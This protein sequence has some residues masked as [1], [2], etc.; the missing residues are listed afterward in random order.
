MAGNEFE[1]ETSDFDDTELRGESELDGEVAEAKECAEQLLSRIPS[2]KTKTKKRRK[3]SV[4]LVCLDI[5]SNTMFSIW[6]LCGWG[7]RPVWVCDK[8]ANQGVYLNE[9]DIWIYVLEIFWIYWFCSEFKV[10]IWS[11][12]ASHVFKNTTYNT[13][14][15]LLIYISLCTSLLMIACCTFKFSIDPIFGNLQLRAGS[16]EKKRLNNR[17]YRKAQR[18]MNIPPE[19]VILLEIIILNIGDYII[20]NILWILIFFEW[21]WLQYLN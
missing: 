21:Q 17:E 11:N 14:K 15:S 1:G 7:K 9:D 2:K 20:C 4:L 12:S 10:L 18:L 3:R 13:T 6:I 19:S 5:V 8:K 16:V